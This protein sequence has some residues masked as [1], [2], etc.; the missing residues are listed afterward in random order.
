MRKPIFPTL[1]RPFKDPIF[2]RF[3]DQTN[4]FLFVKLLY[5]Y[6]VAVL[7]SRYSSEQRPR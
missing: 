4:D 7:R 5:Y 3:L 6:P 2:S 1:K